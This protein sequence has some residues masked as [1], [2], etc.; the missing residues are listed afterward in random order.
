M[1]PVIWD[2]GDGLQ[3]QDKTN[4]M[5]R[6]MT[7]ITGFTARLIRHVA[8]VISFASWCANGQVLSA[9]KGDPALARN[10]YDNGYY[11]LSA[12]E[13]SRVAVG[14]EDETRAAEAR[15]EMAYAFW[16]MDDTKAAYCILDSIVA[17]TNVA[18]SI[19]LHALSL[20]VKI[21]LSSGEFDLAASTAQRTLARDAKC[22][23]EMAIDL[24]KCIAAERIVHMDRRK[25]ASMLRESSLAPEEVIADIESRDIP[26]R[27]PALAGTLSAVLPGSGQAYCGRWRD[28]F[29][30]FSVNA[31]LFGA[32][33]ECFDE[34][35]PMLGGAVV[36]A[37]ITWYMGNIFNAMNVAHRRNDEKLAM[38]ANDWLKRLQIGLDEKSLRAGFRFSF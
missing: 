17:Q 24:K 19:C 36:V 3:Q 18:E 7:T 33:Y 26:W 4:F 13:W 32:A 28:G 12:L 15:L 27:S 1:N 10:L 2:P 29:A 34:D 5:I 35:L 9:S 16:R 14:E 23:Q 21:A 38:I 20:K 22:T 6:W 25:A 8:I 30:A 31:V 37:G 11:V